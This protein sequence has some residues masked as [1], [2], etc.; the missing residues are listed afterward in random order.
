METRQIDGIRVL[1]PSTPEELNRAVVS[2]KPFHAPQELARDFG[3]PREP[4]V[5]DGED[6]GVLDTEEDA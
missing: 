3:L 1:M 4:H 5:V 2:G 6:V